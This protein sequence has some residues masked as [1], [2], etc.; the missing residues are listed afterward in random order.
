M[1][2]DDIIKLVSMDNIGV[3]S[4]EIVYKSGGVIVINVEFVGV[5]RQPEHIDPNLFK[6]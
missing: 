6:I 1:T 5:D 2:K 3:N 4:V